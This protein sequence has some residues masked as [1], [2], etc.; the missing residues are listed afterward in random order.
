[1]GFPRQDYQSGLPFPSPGHLPDARIKPASLE[2]PAL[3]EDSLPLGH[4]GSPDASYSFLKNNYFLCFPEFIPVKTSGFL[5]PPKFLL[6]YAVKFQSWFKNKV[7]LSSWMHKLTCFLVQELDLVPSTGVTLPTVLG[8]QWSCSV[9]SD[10]FATP[11][12]VTYQP[13]LFVEFSRLEYWSGLP[14]PSP[15]STNPG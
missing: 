4:L 12:K 1:M 9:V 8:L 2:S 15:R 6:R 13:S 3:P 14:F 10:S 11:C 7:F 5:C